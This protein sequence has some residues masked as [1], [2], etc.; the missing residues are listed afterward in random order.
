MGVPIDGPTHTF[1]DNMSVVPAQ[2]NKSR[3]KKK[4]NAIAYHYVG[5]AA[6]TM[7]ELLLDFILT[8]HNVADILTKV[9]PGGVKR[10]S[11]IQRLL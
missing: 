4:S 9:L 6:C 5:E 7:G 1:L 10:Y 2:H 8:E 11:L 3:L